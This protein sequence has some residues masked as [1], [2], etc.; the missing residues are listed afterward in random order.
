M[1]TIL[2]PTF[3]RAATIERLYE[4][5]VEMPERGFEWLV[6]D[7]GSNDDTARHMHRLQQAS[8]FPVR[9]QWQPN[10][11]KHIAINAGVKAARGDW[12]FIVDSDDAVTADAMTRIE[13][14]IA[15]DVG[16][17][18]VGVCFRKELF[19]GDWVGREKSLCHDKPVVMSPTEAGHFFQ[20]DLA[21]VFRRDVLSELPF[22]KIE[23]ERFVP[24]MYIWNQAA[25]RGDILFYPKV[26]IYRCDY[27][28]DGY[29]RN[30]KR[31][32]RRNPRGFGLFYASQIRREKSWIIKGKVALRALQCWWY[33]RG[34]V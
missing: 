25:D 31:N 18:H 34:R 20:G 14:A 10:G 2:T 29:S 9:Y 21:Y 15:Q 7:D 12:V 6:V 1:I 17:Q 4:S 27:L 26:S 33:A 11:G 24:E 22:P 19:S 23:G 32:L 3:N 28:E 30:F 8:P 5:L 16:P 13:C